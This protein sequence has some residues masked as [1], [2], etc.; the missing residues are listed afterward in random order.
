[1]ADN[2]FDDCAIYVQKDPSLMI[3]RIANRGAAGPY[4][5]LREEGELVYKS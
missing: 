4:K 1:M 5:D 2:L 3:G